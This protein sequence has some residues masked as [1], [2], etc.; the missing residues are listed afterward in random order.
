MPFYESTFIARQDLS[1]QDIA[2]LTDNFS[3]II[4]AGGGKVV[5]TEYWGLRNLAYR[6]K[7]NRKGHYAM[8]AIDAPFEAVKELQRNLGISEEVMRAVTVRVEKIDEAPSAIMQ[9]RSSRDESYGD[10]AIVPQDEIVV[11]NPIL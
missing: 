11:V 2:R 8:L 5:K 3:N 6:I 10:E 1:K 9:Q 4:T 7:K